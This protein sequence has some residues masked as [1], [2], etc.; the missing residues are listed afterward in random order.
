MTLAVPAFAQTVNGSIRGYVKDATG[1]ALPGI[2][3]ATSTPA[4]AGARSTVS[5]ASGFYRLQNLPPGDYTVTAEQP[6]FARFAQAGI[7]IRAEVNLE[8]SIAMKV[9]G[10]TEVV[11]VKA[12][13]PMLEVDKTVQAVNITGDFQR[14]IPL[15]TKHSF[16]DFMFL[17]PG[18]VSQDLGASG[19]FFMVHGSPFNAHVMQ[20][21]GADVGSAQVGYTIGVNIGNEILEDVQVKTGAMDAASPMATGAVMG[22]VSKSGTNQF[23]GAFNQ[24]LQQ[25]KWSGNNQPGGTT[26]AYT[27]VESAISSGGP[28]KRDKMWFFGSYRYANQISNIS[29]TPAQLNNLKGLIS[30]WQP[31]DTKLKT[32]FVFVKPT[33]QLSP[34]HQLS[35]F[36]EF[37][38]NL[39]DF[40]GPQQDKVFGLSGSKATTLNARLASVWGTALTTRLTASFNNRGSSSGDFVEP[41]PQRQIYTSISL[42]GG[43][44][45][46]SGP[47]A[48]LG[49]NATV[50]DT[51][52]SK[53]TIGF[54]A[55]YFKRGLAG[56]HE[57]QA[58]IYLQP[59]LHLKQGNKSANGGVNI[60]QEVLR[61]PTNPAAG[62]IPFDQFVQPEHT[63]NQNLD[64]DDY[65]FYVQDAWRPMSRLTLTPGVRIDLV[66]RFDNVFNLPAQHTTEVA[67]KIGG[68]Y[69]L[70]A[71]AKNIVRGS[72]GRTF[73]NPSIGFN[74]SAGTFSF[75]RSTKYDLDLNGTFETVIFNPGLTT[76]TLNRIIDP[77]I[78]HQPHVDEALGGY[79]R[80]LSKQF[81][82]D[83]SVMRREFR[84]TVDGLDVN[85]IIDNGVFKG[86]RDVNQNAITKV[87]NNTWNWVVYR[88]FEVTLT[89]QTGNLQLLTSYTRQLYDI[90]GA[91]QPIDPAG[92]ISPNSF[93]NSG[94]VV[95][96]GIA[97]QPN[98]LSGADSTGC[99]Q[100]IPHLFRL[101]SSFRAPLGINVSGSLSV[102]GGQY[103]G[104]IV[105]RIPAADPA[106]GP[107]TLVVVNTS[108]VARTV[109]NPLAT[110]VRFAYPTRGEG[111][112]QL[113]KRGNLSL[114]AG[115]VFKLG[116]RRLEASLD[117]LNV[118]NSDADQSFL[119][120][121]N[122]QYSANYG[123]KTLRVSPRTAQFAMRFAF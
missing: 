21:D 107:A 40:S 80:Q 19:Y 47:I 63:V 83:V 64:T 108:G 103:S 119:G 2:I 27:Y 74:A 46:G 52:V 28:I 50:G 111:Q 62:T 109:T 70:T 95:A 31:F 42:S 23:T 25:K 8:L 41:G 54:D 123:L 72:W 106:F 17:A 92:I 6:G 3:V 66:R 96:G 32:D 90:A 97:A 69:L 122:Q 67:P 45:V 110:T 57:L 101:A 33:M 120:G 9:G 35:G 60:Q 20:L 22:M 7:T 115:R 100:C 78:L 94:G 56:T 59:V 53:G 30:G 36:Y 82:L 5:D 93:P 11:N 84:D 99:R 114:R 37:D 39:G 104:P 113:K 88:M 89:R 121:A 116:P 10:P 14:S 24:V 4:A 44:W 118:T 18:V 85:T 81:S 86:Y 73:E 38:H 13:T 34:N 26:S 55:T 102:Q 51:M 43:V 15:T 98:G 75:D 76:V 12:D 117:L 58:G 71:D 29:R 87:V 65:A 16:A 49:N 91:Y 112:L 105:V 77:N 79:R 48:T 1:A 61:D 68:T